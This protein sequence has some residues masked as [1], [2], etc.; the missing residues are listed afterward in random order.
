MNK[1]E[2][3]C[4][5]GKIL[6]IKSGRCVNIDGAI[7]KKILAMGKKTSP[8]KSS[9]KEPSP[10]KSS[11]KESSPKEPGPK[12]SSPKEPSPKKRDLK[13]SIIR[14]LAVIRDFEKMNNNTYKAKAYTIVLAQLYG[15]KGEISNYKDFED[16]IK[17]GDRIN[18][19]VKE[20]IDTEKIKYE[21]EN[22]KKDANYYF[23]IELRKIYGIGDSN[24]DKLLKAGIKSIDDLK[25]NTHLLNEKQKIG[26]KYYDD[27]NKR[28]PEEEYLKHKKI[29]EKDLK[30]NDITYDF[31]GSFRRGNSSMGDIDVLIMKN[32][33][34]DLPTYIKKL[35]DSEYIKEVLALG[36]VKFSGIVKLDDASIARRID[37][38]VSPENEYYYSLLYFTG[39]A[40]FNVGMRNY[41]KS[42]Y[43]ISLSEH[44]F[45]KDV[46]KIPA[47]NKEKDIFNFFNIKYV[48]PAKRK[49]FFTPS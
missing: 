13:K 45:D 36:K 30:L 11:S 20:L 17:A 12:K 22:I 43:G 2:K 15:Y 47:M 27:L 48:E 18:K 33:N 25:K 1:E 40:E 28:I 9:P 23:Q 19:K 39:S 32:D 7:G 26:L 14:H 31:A 5:E 44:G 49:A 34:F 38:L 29:L 24:I 46:I 35:Q 3:K 6:N 10:K 21:E 8:K 16:N 42:K 41:I 37:I 4:P